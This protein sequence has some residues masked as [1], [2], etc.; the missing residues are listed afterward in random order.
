MLETALMG[1]IFSIFQDFDR[2]VFADQ[3]AIPQLET[4]WGISNPVVT[5]VCD[6]KA[7]LVAELFLLGQ[8]G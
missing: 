8:H 2:R 1:T 4:Y 7:N 5:R 3:T 6:S